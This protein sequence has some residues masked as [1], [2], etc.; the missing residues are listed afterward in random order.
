MDHE[1]GHDHGHEQETSRSSSPP[2]TPNPDGIEVDE[3]RGLEDSEPVPKSFFDEIGTLHTATQ[4]INEKIA[5]I[6]RL[7]TE[8]LSKINYGEVAALNEEAD[9]LAAELSKMN[10]EMTE[11]LRNLASRTDPESGDAKHVQLVHKNFKATVQHYNE[12]E[13]NYQ[14]K[15]REQLARQYKI[16]NPE[17]TDEEIREV[18]ESG[19]TSI[20][21][22]AVM[23]ARRAQ[24]SAALNAVKGRFEEIQRIEKTMTELADLFGQLNELVWK[25][26]D[27]IQHIHDHAADVE[28]NL[29]AGNE[30]LAKAIEHSKGARKKKLWM[31]LI[32]CKWKDYLWFEAI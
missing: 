28:M 10:Q 2:R 16:V 15:M 20:F 32:L 13:I 31:C 4:D 30:D 5:E 24:G 6:E 26:E 11:K 17:A 8:S 7:H 21:V 19:D 18:Q 22:S 9:A 12:T 23:D 29:A 27:E 25:Q 3:K 1:S 14:T